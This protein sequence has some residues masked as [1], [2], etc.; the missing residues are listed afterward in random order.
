MSAILTDGTT[1][2]TWTDSDFHADAQIELSRSKTAG[3]VWKT[4]VAGER[5]VASESLRLTEAQYRSLVNLLKANYNYLYYT[6][7]SIP[8]EYTASQFPMKV[9]VDLQQKKAEAY[10][11]AVIYHVMLDI[12]SA[13]L[14]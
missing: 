10:N 11:G 12:Q 8:A 6:P 7:N 4:Q 2:L 13:E 14:L 5:M 3:A 9:T 1:S